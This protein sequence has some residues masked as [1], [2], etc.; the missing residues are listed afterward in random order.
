MWFRFCVRT[1]CFQITNT[2]LYYAKIIIEDQD[3]Y[4]VND[5][6]C[7]SSSYLMES[8]VSRLEAAAALLLLVMPQDQKLATISATT[9]PRHYIHCNDSTL[10]SVVVILYTCLLYLSSFTW[11]KRP[12][13]HD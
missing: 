5:E 2:I 13:S 12:N 9:M 11:P 1:E 8:S 4:E 3:Y 6:A 7:C 10:K